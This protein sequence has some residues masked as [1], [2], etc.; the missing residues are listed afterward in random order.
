MKNGRAVGHFNVSTMDM[1]WA[2][3]RAA[4]GLKEP[5]IIGFSEGERDFIGVKQAPRI[6]QSIREEFDY[7]VFC[8]A[9][10][11]YSFERVKEA[12][13]AGFDAVIFDGAKLS[14]EENIKLTRQCV[15]YARK[16][17][18][19]MLVEAE[20]GYIG[21]SSS[22]RDGLPAG[23]TM[24]NLT[25]PA[26]ALRFVRETGVDLFAPSVGN[27]HGMYRGGGDPALH[28][29]RVKEIS[30]AVKIPL[31]LH[32]A[33]GNTAEDIRGAIAAGVGIVHVSTELRVAYRGAL[34]KSLSSDPNQVAPYRYLAPA[35]EA[36]E[37][38]VAEKLKIFNGL[39]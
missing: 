27:V 14:I 18:P 6:I 2:I 29:D 37:K 39:A 4:Q 10:H 17:R 24:E 11:T 34:E 32:G 36:M 28:V 3:F 16:N 5:V 20:L 23:V 8:N 26:D 12:V 33:S 25:S 19:G 30:E 38:V 21:Q 1:I 15:E 35:G 22:L 13:D 9:D 7:P 31:V